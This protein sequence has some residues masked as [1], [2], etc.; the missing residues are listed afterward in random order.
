[1]GRFFCTIITL[2]LFFTQII[3][4]QDSYQE[5]LYT[6]KLKNDLSVFVLPDSTEPFVNIQLVIKAGLAHQTEE[7]PGLIPIRT[8]MF[9]SLEKENQ[10]LLDSGASFFANYDDVA[11]Y[12]GI[13]I[14]PEKTELA[15]STFGEQCFKPFFSDSTL[16]KEKEEYLTQIQALEKT[17]TLF[18]N[19]KVATSITSSDERQH[20]PGIS[21]N[22]LS[23]KSTAQI[24]Q[25][26]YAL[27]QKLYTP[28]N[29]AIFIHGVL[30]IYQIESLI[31]RY[32]GQYTEKKTESP[33]N[34]LI[35]NKD[36]QH[37]FLLVSD[38]FS[39]D[40]N[41]IIIQ[42]P[43]DTNYAPQEQAIATDLLVQLLTEKENQGLQT[44]VSNIEKHISSSHYIFAS[45]DKFLGN[46]RLV[47]QGLANLS[48]NFALQINE[49]KDSI[50]SYLVNK[51]YS[52]NL[53]N[54]IKRLEIQKGEFDSSK[55]F[56]EN[57]AKNFGETGLPF[58]KEFSID[59]IKKIALTSLEKTPYCYVLMN[60]KNYE[61]NSLQ[62]ENENFVVIKEVDT[63]FQNKQNTSAETNIEKSSSEIPSENLPKTFDA[64][65]NFLANQL[66]LFKSK[67]LS[68]GI[69]V[70]YKHSPL[71]SESAIRLEISGGEEKSFLGIRGMESLILRIVTEN[72]L[73]VMKE[74]Y[75]SDA[76]FYMPEI[77]CETGINSGS[78]TIKCHSQDIYRC[79]QAAI[80]SIVFGDVTPSIA[81]E[82]VFNMQREY[83]FLAADTSFQT[84][85]NFMQRI[86]P[87]NKKLYNLKTPLLANLNFENIQN[88][89]THILDA[90][91]Y[92]IIVATSQD[93]ESVTKAAEENF[94]ILQ[95]HPKIKI[96]T[97]NEIAEK[98]TISVPE[99]KE[100]ISLYRVF[101]TDIPAEL[102][103]ERPA[104]LIPTTEFND[105]VHYYSNAPNN[106]DELPLYNSLLFEMEQRIEK[107]T[108]LEVKTK[109]AS[110]K[111]PF[112]G[113]QILSVPRLLDIDA[114]LKRT[115]TQLAEDILSQKGEDII[116]GIKTKWQFNIL[117]D[118]SSNIAV[119]ELIAKGLNETG[120]QIQY[121]KDFEIINKATVVEFS[122]IMEEYLINFPP[123]SLYSESRLK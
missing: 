123:A 55:K 96:T 32:F 16:R 26:L 98:S 63:D 19:Q 79:L 65:Q 113:L 90:S 50:K 7:F 27:N 12:Y 73:M 22:E 102:A 62:F 14:H 46:H 119:T 42:F 48:E 30:D 39:P 94:G 109:I 99:I 117:S 44:I 54:S 18:I 111:S 101:T 95:K 8:K 84:Y 108:G 58:T 115:A 21:Y 93:F 83:K 100:Y 60:S 41:Q 38:N 78:I 72:M 61:E 43:C 89:Y 116:M 77:T 112:G 118:I 2:F 69:P 85:C 1:M 47:V 81:D 67:T 87:K 107:A 56:M 110:V 70:I 53:P 11:T 4:A 28:D 68:N 92:T 52:E 106:I 20:Y 103:G 40:L 122:K 9:F 80:G 15:L 33:S 31:N 49:I 17:S 37:N 36:L 76:I 82:T 34:S 104:K 6:F 88:A 57:L 75:N 120:S 29:C 13:K 25:E 97:K 86:Y 10:E 121:L 24:R 74:Y 45:K 3:F 71:Q 114:V 105:P 35:K 51:L 64:T 59:E 23:K 66:E 5:K 91:R